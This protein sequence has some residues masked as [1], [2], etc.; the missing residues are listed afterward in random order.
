MMAMQEA[1][2][3]LSSLLSKY[4]GGIVAAEEWQPV[5]A[6]ASGRCLLRAAGV[7]GIYWTAERADNNSFLPAAHGLHRAGIRVPE[8]LAER[9]LPGGCGACL[10]TDLGTRE[11]S[12]LRHAAWEERKQA[13]TSAFQTLIPFYDLRPDWPLQPPFDVDLYRWEQEYFAEHLLGRHLGGDA[14]AF[15]AAPALRE[16][17][18]WLASL[19][20]V[21]VHRDCQSPNIMLCA[22]EAWL[23]DFQGM[24]MGLKEYDLA[25][26]LFDS[27]MPM[28]PEERVELLRLWQ[29]L[30]GR[31]VESAVFAACALQRLMQALGAYANI[32]YNQ[33][34]PQYLDL[35]P[36]ALS[37][38]RDAALLAPP[39]SPASSIIPWLPVA[40]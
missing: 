35:I 24:R 2:A 3:V 7:L 30:G 16:M 22:G 8:V 1:R 29:E 26:L 4:R 28:K 6:G 33:G 12:S 40:D 23:V 9:H 19:P 10:V 36:T 20:R 21:P 38:L 37:A 18:E 34:K 39:A 25:S 14:E 13:Y 5:T 17:A 15:L 31:P 27:H 32:G 11:L